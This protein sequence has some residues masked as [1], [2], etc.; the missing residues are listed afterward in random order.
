MSI[1]DIALEHPLDIDLILRKRKA[2]KKEYLFSD[3]FVELNIAILGGSTTS[4]I[5]NIFGCIVW[6]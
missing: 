1:F 4:E 3:K 6:K 2:I 5:K